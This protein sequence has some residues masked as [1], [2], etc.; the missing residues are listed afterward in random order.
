VPVLTEAREAGVERP[1]SADRTI[2]RRRAR[3]K[4]LRLASFLD[5]EVL[6]VESQGL[7]SITAGGAGW[8]DHQH[9]Q[10]RMLPAK[11]EG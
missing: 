11:L 3:V 5:H 4:R 2:N 9:G 6:A 7:D 1:G 10:L 8:E